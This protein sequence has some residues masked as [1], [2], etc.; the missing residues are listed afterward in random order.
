MAQKKFDMVVQTGSYVD[1]NGVEKKTYET[2]GSVFETDKGLF[3]LLNRTFNPAGVAS[4]RSTI[5][6]NFYTPRVKDAP[7]SAKAP[8]QEPSFEDDLPW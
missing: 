6:V 5:M 4:D 8:R 1:R 2:I 7:A 3:G